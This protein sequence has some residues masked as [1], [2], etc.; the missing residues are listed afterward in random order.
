MAKAQNERLSIKPLGDRVVV[1]PQAKEEKTASGIFIPDSAKQDS[2]SK[3]TVVAVGSGRY[4]DGKLVPM[5]VKVGDTVLFSKYGFDEV[6]VDGQ[7]YCILSES[8]VLAVLS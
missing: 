7:E 6:K 5:T 8:S 2:P 1:K 4:D 3:G